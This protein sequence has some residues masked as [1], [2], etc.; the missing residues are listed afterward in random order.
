[1]S[2]LCWGLCATYTRDPNAI[3]IHPLY[4]VPV[5]PPKS[6]APIP[7][8]GFD[9]SPTST[10]NYNSALFPGFSRTEQSKGK[11]RARK[12]RI[13]IDQLWRETSCRLFRPWKSPGKSLVSWSTGKTQSI[14]RKSW[15]FPSLLLYWTHCC[16][17]YSLLRGCSIRIPREVAE[18]GYGYLEDRRPSSNCDPYS[19]GW[20]L[21]ET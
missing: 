4:Q 21:I 19:V 12:F 20:N 9:P 5:S 8:S 7:G 17:P 2:P 3:C 15:A 6:L 13:A 11:G 1:M 16:I 18:K 10:G 14:R